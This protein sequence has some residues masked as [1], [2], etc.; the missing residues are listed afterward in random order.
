MLTIITYSICLN[1]H[2][3][4]TFITF[5]HNLASQFLELILPKQL[6][7]GYCHQGKLLFLGP[8]TILLPRISIAYNLVIYTNDTYVILVTFKG[9]CQRSICGKN[10]LNS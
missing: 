5:L 4:V 9:H 6:Q 2:R 3:P 8:S 10:G 7:A 1:I